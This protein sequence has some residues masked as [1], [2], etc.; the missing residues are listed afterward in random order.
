VTYRLWASAAHD[1]TRITAADALYPY[2]FAA[3]WSVKRAPG[4][5][6]EYDPA[7][8]AATATARQALLGVRVVKVDSDVRR[9]SDVT[10]TYVVPVV[11]VYLSA[12]ST[13]AQ[14]LAALAPPWSA[15]PWHVTVLMEEA[16]KRG[17]G[18]FSAAEARRRGVRWLDLARDPKTREELGAILQELARRNHIP[19]PL[20]RLVAADE[21]QTR[22]AALRQFVQ[23]RG[24][25]LV[26]N[27]PYQ[28]EKWTDTAVVLQ[29]FRDLNNPLGVGS[30]D[31]FAIPRRAWVAR[32]TA[33]GERLEIMPEIER[34][35][36]FQREYRLVREPL[37]ARGEEDKIDVPAAHYVILAADGS[38]AA[39]GTSRE[40]QAHRVIVDL[41]GRLKPGA[42]TALVALA[43]GENRVD[44]DVAAAQFRV[45]AG[46]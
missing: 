16:V 27:G 41:N 28:L 7:I 17:V 29:V 6:P 8:E 26:T 14:E 25:F 9:Y 30:Y 13:D 12:A 32:L 42:Y 43:L 31:R 20:K 34:L 38:V 2:V 46:P 39:A 5:P 15:V 40:V 19:E 24:H 35:E 1:N 22:W 10:F 36:K 11:E 44:P 3:R 37:W 18:A 4:S 21:A 45:D 23:R 33:R